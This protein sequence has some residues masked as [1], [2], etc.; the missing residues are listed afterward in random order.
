MST[1]T[2]GK[3]MILSMLTLTLV[4]GVTACG[5]NSEKKPASQVAVKVNNEEISIHQINYVL[6]H[7]PSLANIPAEKAPTVRREILNK[8]IDQQLAVEQALEKK[9]DRSPDVIMAIDASR[10]EILARAYIEQLSGEQAKPSIDEARKYFAEHPALFAERRIFNMQELILPTDQ[11]I[12]V[13]L[14]DMTAAGKPM[15]EIAAWLKSKEIKFSA[16]SASRTAEQIPLELLPKVHALQDGQGLVLE[17]PQNITVMRLI[18]SQSA[19]VT[20]EVALPRIQQYL[21][22]QRSI[23]VTERTLKELRAKAKIAYQG[24]FAEAEAA[25]DAPAAK[26]AA[27]KKPDPSAIEKGAAALK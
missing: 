21:A 3:R 27:E 14:K 7:N 18:A 1:P 11:A 12:A 6:S 16:A 8:L 15:E 24:E 22:N 17:T 20:E 4:L 13:Q 10:R 5:N 25:T 26:P 2:L 9:L 19:P 23:E